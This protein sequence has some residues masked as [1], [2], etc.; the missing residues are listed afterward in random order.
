M[1]RYIDCSK[2]GEKNVKHYAKELCY[3]C[4]KKNKKEICSLCGE[5]KRVE[6][7]STD[8]GA[9][10][11]KCYEK[12][13]YEKPREVCFICGKT[14]IVKKRNENKEPICP[15]CYE[16]PLRICY[17]C[18][19]KRPAA[20]MIGKNKYLCIKCFK[21]P[22]IECGKMEKPHLRK[23]EGAVCEKCYNKNHYKKPKEICSICNKLK[24]VK[25]RID[26]KAICNVCYQR[27]KRKNDEIHHIK[28]ILRVRLASAFRKYST[29]GKIKPA[30]EYGIDYES[31][32]LHLG[33]CP[34]DRSEYHIDHIFPISAFDFNNLAHIQAAFAPKNHRWLK[35]NEN[36]SKNN[37]FD[38]TE[39]QEYLNA[40]M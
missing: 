27:E 14:N 3:K 30:D 39:F 31:I 4:Y 26:K 5:E 18:G 36:W 25:M 28:N 33:P 20:K 40:Y 19:E 22:C 23:K 29:T 12:L 21:E 9:I 16:Y 34:G 13:F 38:E 11:P 37:K 15:K 24:E 6:K 1:P 2:C 35:N 10:C 32:I 7:R 8:G 17:K